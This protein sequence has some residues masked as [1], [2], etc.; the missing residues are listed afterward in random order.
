MVRLLFACFERWRWRERRRKGG[1][2]EA[3]D[4]RG[5]ER[6]RDR[7]RKKVLTIC[8]YFVYRLIFIGKYRV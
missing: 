1:G 6:N 4:K 7:D 3:G 8:K 5:N 2:E